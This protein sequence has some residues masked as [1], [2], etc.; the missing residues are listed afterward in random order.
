[1]REIK[2][3]IVR[4]AHCEAIFEEISDKVPPCPKCGGT[5]ELVKSGEKF[6]KTT[7]KDPVDELTVKIKGLAQATE[8]AVDQ[9]KQLEEYV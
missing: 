8:E 6:V 5:L 9:L 2:G 7:R 3:S 1:M 4:C